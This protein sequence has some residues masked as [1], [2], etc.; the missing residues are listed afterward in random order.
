MCGTPR[1]CHSMHINHDVPKRSLSRTFK[2]SRH[3]VLQAARP[4]CER[5]L[6]FDTL[7][8]SKVNVTN[9]FHS[10]NPSTHSAHA[11]CTSLSP[12]PFLPPSTAPPD[13]FRDKPGEWAYAWFERS[14]RERPEPV[15]L[16]S[17]T[18]TILSCNSRFV[19]FVS[20]SYASQVSTPLAHR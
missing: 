4:T 13:L 19:S 12:W 16:S 18:R 11:S 20:R 8:L 17:Q 10:A 7:L 2:K 15:A 5:V 9:H 3:A 6:S 1:S 14:R